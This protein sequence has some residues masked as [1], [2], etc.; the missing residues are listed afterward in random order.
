MHGY[1]YRFEFAEPVQHC[2]RFHGVM[3]TPGYSGTKTSGQVSG[4]MTL[5]IHSQQQ[6]RQ[7]PP[8]TPPTTAVSNCLRDGNRERGPQVS[9]HNCHSMADSMFFFVSFLV[10]VN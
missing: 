3:G 6:S 10:F 2:T 8:L 7:P 1:G 9:N 5:L 4:H